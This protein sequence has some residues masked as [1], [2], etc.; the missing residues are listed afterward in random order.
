[1]KYV[2]LFRFSNLGTIQLFFCVP[3]K[4]TL[5]I[6]YKGTWKL[7]S[8]CRLLYLNIYITSQRALKVY[9][10]IEEQVDTNGIRENMKN[11]R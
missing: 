2:T 5:V 11:K 3:P 4:G 7:I 9:N 8:L 1:M 6:V 10:E